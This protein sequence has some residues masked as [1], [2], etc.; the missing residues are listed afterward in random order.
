M[1]NN[2]I[3]KPIKG[4][5]GLYSISNFGNVRSE[6]KPFTYNLCGRTGTRIN[7]G[8]KLKPFINTKANYYRVCFCVNEKREYLLVHR[9]VA[10]AFV[11]NPDSKPCVNHK[12][13]NKH[14]N[15]ADNLEWVT[16]SENTQHAIDTGL[17]KMRGE[18]NPNAIFTEQQVREMRQLKNTMPVKDIAIS[19]G[20]GPE[21][22]R[23]VINNRC[24]KHIV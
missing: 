1:K 15:A 22:V 4:Y 6:D 17:M 19:Y 3:W 7:K 9:L 10:L 13:G 21:A 8:R 2:E 5:E 11:L 14:N 20:C 23:Q 18:D 12:D 24:W 16:Y